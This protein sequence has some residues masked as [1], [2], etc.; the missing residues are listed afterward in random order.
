MDTKELINEIN[1]ADKLDE[2]TLNDISNVVSRGYEAD[3][4]S[5]KDWLD[6]LD[7]YTQMALQIT[8]RKT[9]PWENASNVKFPLLATAAQQF[10]ARAYPTLVPATGDIVKCRVIG[11]DPQGQKEARAI[12]ISKHM[13]YQLC[14]EMT[15]WEEDMDRLLIALPIAGT[16]FKKSYFDTDL[17]RNKSCIVYPKNLIV[18]YWAKCLETA[19]RVTEVH[20]MSK[21]VI[22]E[23]QLA[24]VYLDIDL[25]D[26]NYSNDQISKSDPTERRPVEN[27]ET[28]PYV[29][30]EQ[31]T[32][33]DLDDDGYPEPYI[34]VF[35]ENSKKILRI[36]ARFTEENVKVD[37]DKILKITPTQYYTKFSFFPNPDGGFYDVGFGRLLGSLNH[38]VDTIVNQLIDAGTLS[39]LQSGFISKGLKMKM[40]DSKFTPGEWKPVNAT[41]QDLKSGILPLPTGQPSTVLYQL[42]ELLIQN[43]KELASI[44]EIFVGKMP[45][46]N[47]PAT[48]TMATVQEG[49]RLFTAIYKR[50]YRALGEEFRKLYVLNGIYLNDQEEV[51]VLDE[52]IQQSDYHGNPNDVVP[53]ADPSAASQDI[54]AQKAER[55]AQ[56]L[57]LGT[58]N[59]MEVTKRMLI[60][61]E[62]PDIEKLIQQPP[63]PPPD[64]KMEAMKLKAQLDQKKAESDLQMKQIDAQIKMAEGQQ[65]MELE[66]QK[67]EQ[68]LQ[69][70]AEKAAIEKQIAMVEARQSFAHAQQDHEQTMKNNTQLANAKAAAAAKAPS[71]GK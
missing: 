30:L 5:L 8:S 51:D 20:E 44:S 1:I 41:G 49:M 54:R 46:Q 3:K 48:T 9:Y 25:G 32:F 15:E 36:T 40:G 61:Y 47:T 60:A 64:P 17:G 35:E 19:E 12:R 71:K 10:A 16:V 4:V 31:H 18:N 53:S 42:L 6:A 45:G 23:K 24:G 11:S 63:P 7:K 57:Q 26:P 14:Y 33:Y 34:I 21:R 66:R 69:F 55:L 65:K 67:H 59:P 62:E 56:M 43:S 70:A 22:R 39:N 68:E 2:K 28:T 38:S 37:G 27:D 29:I 13:S 58:I 52:P 50:V